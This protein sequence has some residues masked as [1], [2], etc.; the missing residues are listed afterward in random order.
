MG[1]SAF[2]L[3]AIYIHYETSF[4]TFH[5]KSD[6]IFRTTYA[7]NSGNGYDVHWARIP[8]NYINELPNEIPEIEQLIRLQNSERKYIRVGKSKFKSNHAYTTDNEIFSVFDLPAI[9]GDLSSALKEPNSVVITESLAI[10]YFGKADVLNEHIFVLGGWSSDEKQYKVTAV[11]EDLPPQTHLPI[12]ILFSFQNPEARSG[13]AY[14]YLLLE[15]G[16]DIELVKSKIAQFIHKHADE[17]S[18]DKVKFEF[19]ALESIHLHSK[20]A[21]EIVPNGDFAYIKI[22]IGIG[23]FILLVALVNYINLNSALI[24]DRSKEIG[25]RKILGSDNRQVIYYLLTESVAI[26]LFSM[27]LAILLAF[28]FFPYFSAITGISFILNPW[29]LVVALI[30]LATF[31]GLVAGI[32]P[33]LSIPKNN[34]L[35][36]LKSIKSIGSG[37]AYTFNLKRALVMLQYAISIMLIGSALIARDQFKFLNESNLGLTREQV[38]AIP[39]VPDGVKDDFSNFKE[40]LTNTSDINGITACMEVPSREIRDA[41]PVLVKGVNTETEKAPMMDIQIIDHNYIDVLNIELLAGTNIPRSLSDYS[42]PE[43]TE[44]YTYQEYLIN[45]RRA[46]LINETAMKQMGFKSP[47]EA[48]GQEVNWSNG[49][50]ELSFGP[51]V[52]IVKDYHQ[53]TMKNEIDPTIMVFEPI[54]LRT[55]L[56]KIETDHVQETIKII[57]SSWDE[58]FPL[59]PIEYHFL[60]ELY[61]ALYKGERVKLQLLYLLSGL[62]I[63]ISFIGLFGLIAYSLNTRIKE[64]AIRKVLGADVT[65]LIRMISKEYLIILVAGAIVAI[66]FSYYFIDQWLQQFAY[67]INISNINYLWTVLI[68]ALLIILTIGF[69]TIRTSFINPADTLHDE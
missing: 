18:A 7:Y 42:V 63:I 32:F 22:F 5:A 51:I 1:F 38:L 8:I 47:E 61:E 23:M 58:L 12:D 9:S 60:D 49:E 30:L 50:I 56:I 13:W 24:L 4:E 46:Y 54:W 59:Y 15:K 64:I 11:I 3:T 68:I 41:G 26:N 6:R 14:V 43:F 57:K 19:Q 65:S 53:E 67:K 36:Q 34:P 55:F 62:A 52:G 44:D 21:R 29:I 16:T 20:L 31:S 33:L 2:I 25:L 17:N 10:T 69:Q 27:M 39:G 66:P 45:E 35:D 37:K 40:L 48:L 28:A